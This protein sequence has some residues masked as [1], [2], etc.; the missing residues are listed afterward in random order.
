MDVVIL[1]VLSFIL[2]LSG[3]FSN[4]SLLIDVVILVFILVPS[5]D[6]PFIERITPKIPSE[7][8]NVTETLEYANTTLE[9]E[10]KT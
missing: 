4:T 2:Y 10:G 7:S 3:F 8:I 5:P 1:V 6:D 9:T